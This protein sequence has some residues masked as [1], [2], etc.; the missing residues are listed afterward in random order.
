M[1][2]P[3]VVIRIPPKLFNKFNAYIEQTGSS[4]TEVVLSALAQYLECVEDL[5]LTQRM[6][7]LETRITML[8]TSIKNLTQTKTV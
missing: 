2:R 5:P 1:P 6:A 8:E 4:K 3:Q 7:K